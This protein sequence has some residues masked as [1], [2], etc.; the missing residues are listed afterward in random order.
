MK[1]AGPR[2]PDSGYSGMTITTKPVL[3][4]R[5]NAHGTANNSSHPAQQWDGC[6]HR[7]CCAQHAR[8]RTALRLPVM[9]GEH[10]GFSANCFKV[11]MH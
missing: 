7:H 3:T 1:T 10:S 6:S 8:V 11:V 9:S 2:F 5:A 4:H